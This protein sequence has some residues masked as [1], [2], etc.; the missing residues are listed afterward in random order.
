MSVLIE[1]LRIKAFEIRNSKEYREWRNAVLERDDGKCVLCG[2]RKK[3]SKGIRME[4]DH[5]KPFLLFP[6]LAFD[7]NNGRTLCSTCHRK[8]DTYGNSKEHRKAHKELIHPFL[9]GDLLVK[10]KTLP[11]AIKYGEG[12]AGFS[13]K[14][15]QNS[16][17]WTAGYGRNANLPGFTTEGDTADE[18]IDNLV[19]AMRYSA[20]TEFKTDYKRPTWPTKN[21]F[22][23]RI[24]GQLFD[25]SLPENSRL[26]ETYNKSREKMGKKLVPPYKLVES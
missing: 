2:R 6:E 18:A 10:I 11:T 3:P 13:L 1:E 21:N 4:V 23:R 20:T 17:R 12:M 8:T 16:G 26:L 14:Y 9:A 25:L 7:I 22:I 24:G 15:K 5:I 19:L